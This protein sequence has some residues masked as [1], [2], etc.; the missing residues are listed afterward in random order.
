MRCEIC[1][2]EATIPEFHTCPKKV[3]DRIDR[4]HRKASLEA[5]IQERP[6]SREPIERRSP[7]RCPTCGLF[8]D[9]E[10]RCPKV[11]YDHYAGAWEHG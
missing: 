11:F 4:E 10:G 1:G 3:L 2:R 8:C 9:R 5:E 6:E 7:R